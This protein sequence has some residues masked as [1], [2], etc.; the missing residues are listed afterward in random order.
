MIADHPFW[1]AGL[2]NYE[3]KITYY[4]RY[5]EAKSIYAHNFFL[6]FSAETG[7][8]SPVFLLIFLFR[9]RKK[10]A[11]AEYRQKAVFIAAAA[12]MFCYNL[13]DIGFYFFA[14]GVISAVVVSQIYPLAQR[15]NQRAWSF[16]TNP[17]WTALLAVFVMLSALLSV[18]GLSDNQRKE[19]D[20]LKAQKEYGQAKAYYQKSIRLN[21]FNF[22]AMTGYA[23]LALKETGVEVTPESEYYLDRALALNP[24]SPYASYLKSRFEYQNNHYVNALYHAA[25]AHRKNNRVNHY[26]QWYELNRRNLE[27]AI[28]RN[29]T[30]GMETGEERGKIK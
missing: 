3:S 24:D 18:E 9:G 21:P 16:K 22:K 17:A 8:I 4:T 12:V 27:N 7:I 6:Q 11:P 29:K 2:G 14:A 25:A 20:F 23:S 13:I 10:L 5:D 19:A 1:G 30:W 26:K 28:N 15:E